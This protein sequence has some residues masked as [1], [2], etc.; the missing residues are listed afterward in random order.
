M[1]SIPPFPLYRGIGNDI[2][3]QFNQIADVDVV[4]VVVV[5]IVAIVLNLNNFLSHFVRLFLHL[6]GQFLCKMFVTIFI[7]FL[8]KLYCRFF[9]FLWNPSV[10][11]SFLLF[12][13]RGDKAV[14]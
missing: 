13:L 1:L 11:P 5:V 2:K 6:L 8:A 10:R 14:V 3:M 7:G 12:F 4:L 9:D